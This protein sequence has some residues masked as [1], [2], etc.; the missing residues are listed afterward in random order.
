MASPAALAR[1]AEERENE[2]TEI[3]QNISDRLERIEAKLN[4][5]TLDTLSQNE[6]KSAAKTSTKK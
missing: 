4:A 3:I 6:A 1:L 5:L 2:R